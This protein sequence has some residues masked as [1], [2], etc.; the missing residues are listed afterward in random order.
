MRHGAGVRPGRGR[1][2]RRPRRRSRRRVRGTVD[3][4]ERR[5]GSRRSGGTR[6]GTAVR[7]PHRTRRTGGRRPTRPMRYL[8]PWGT[9]R[10]RHRGTRRSGRRR[11]ARRTRG[12]TGRR[13]PRRTRGSGRRRTA[14]RTGGRPRGTRGNFGRRGP[15]R[16]RCGT[17]RRRIRGTRGCTDCRRARRTRR[18][19][20][21]HGVRR[22]RWC[23]GGRRLWRAGWLWGGNRRC[24]GAG[25]GGRDGE[26]PHVRAPR[27]ARGRRAEGGGRVVAAR[28]FEPSGPGRAGGAPGRAVRRRGRRARARGRRARGSAPLVRRRLR[29][30]RRAQGAQRGGRFRPGVRAPRRRARTVRQAERRGTP[31]L[32]PGGRGRHS[33]A[34]LPSR[35]GRRPPST[36]LPTRER[37]RCR[38]HRPTGLPVESR[39]G[40][41]REAGRGRWWGRGRG[42]G[43]PGRL[44]LRGS[45]AGTAGPNDAFGGRRAADSPVPR[46]LFDLPHRTAPTRPLITTLLPTGP[47]RQ[48]VLP[49]GPGPA[50]GYVRPLRPVHPAR[51]VEEPGPV[52]P[53]GGVGR[54]R[55][56]A[57]A[58][59]VVPR[60][61][62]S[63]GHV[64]RVRDIAPAV[65]AVAR[66]GPVGRWRGLP[67]GLRRGG[68]G[69]GEASR[70]RGVLRFAAHAPPFPRARANSSYGPSCSP[71]RRRP[72]PG[73]HTRTRGSVSRRGSGGR[74]V[75]PY[76]RV[77]LRLV[78]ARTATSPRA[79]GFCPDRPPTLR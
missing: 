72:P 22:T 24:R 28:P 62:R 27:A 6:L 13:G 69:R 14:R 71:A 75:P 61:V 2:G 31:G 8:A 42:G 47:S 4:R 78:R 66:P 59:A 43:A 40:C 50:S 68:A 19:A 34:G 16:A 38:R 1:S 25:R 49:G 20:C 64:G 36:G 39:R 32:P 73:T 41:V 15:G 48:L 26:R 29:F 33:A 5:T 56:S 46:T 44:V 7:E 77:T 18:C 37:R 76:L 35:G 9:G 21:R 54:A 58:V 67:G 79:R 60:S 17:R 52:R 23:V 12:N 51:P 65:P 70:V 55:D 30:R 63:A 3:G 11:T 74:A 57:P 53:A 45:E 10:R